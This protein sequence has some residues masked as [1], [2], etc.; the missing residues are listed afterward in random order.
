VWQYHL[1][2]FPRYEGDDLY[3]SEARGTTREERVPYASMLRSAL[4]EDERPPP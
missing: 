1:H 4:A 3:G 2:V